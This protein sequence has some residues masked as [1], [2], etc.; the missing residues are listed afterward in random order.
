VFN[1]TS[2]WVLGAAVAATLLAATEAGL[3]V[4]QRRARAGQQGPGHAGALQASVL[5]LLALLLSFTLSMAL[6]RFENRK[7]LVLE[8]ANAISTTYLRATLLAEDDARR[9]KGL[10]RDYVDARFA[11]YASGSDRA[12]VAATIR[13]AERLHAELWGI[14]AEASRHGPASLPVSQ[15]T[16]SVNTVIDLHDKRVRALEDHVPDSVFILLWLVAV[17]AFGLIGYDGGFDTDR[18]SA[19]AAVVAVLVTLVIVVI[20][21]LDRPRRGL[22]RVSQASM[23]HVKDSIRQP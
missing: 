22:I 16:Q 3:R 19:A 8:E 21:D 14:A 5:G 13:E 10:L 23:Q 7:G 11:F 2:E 18:R 1:Q 4:A 17:G 12:A 9:A 20:V 6:T 15:F